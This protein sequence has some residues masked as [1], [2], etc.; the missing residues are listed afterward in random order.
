[1]V[2]STY[3]DQLED[4]Q[5]RLNSWVDYH[6]RDRNIHCRLNKQQLADHNATKEKISAVV[7]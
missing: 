7:N 4:Y 3:I 1:M 6:K 2:T 5:R